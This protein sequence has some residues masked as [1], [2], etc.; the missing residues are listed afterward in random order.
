[1]DREI[2]GGFA[3][4]RGLRRVS[5]LWASRGRILFLVFQLTTNAASAIPER[6]HD[7]FASIPDR[8]HAPL[9]NQISFRFVSTQ[10]FPGQVRQRIRQYHSAGFWAS[11]CN[12][13]RF[14]IRY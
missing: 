9:L 14:G 10:N 13:K 5:G 8:S 6:C 12:C 4:S 7:D 2:L 3:G 1:M 11:K